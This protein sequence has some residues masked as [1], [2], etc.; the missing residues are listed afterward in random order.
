MSEKP[1]FTPSSY[2][3]NESALSSKYTEDEI[4]H[5][6]AEV[7]R[8]QAKRHKRLHALEI[9]WAIISTIFAII[10]TAILLAKNWVEGAVSY[11]ILGILI[12][13]I[14]VFLVL[15]ALVYKKP[16]SDLS[17]KVYGKTI[18]IFKALASIAFLVLT[19]MTMAAMVKENK[20]L[21]LA[22]WAIF[23]GNLLVAVV[24]LVIKLASL[25]SY[26]TIRH[27]S[28]HYSVQVSRYVDGEEQKKT[29]ADR[30]EEKKFK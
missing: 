12:A 4:M 25:I 20:H 17:F 26:L 8:E 3:T 29:F 14:I 30:H 16:D 5:A 23:I 21:D 19:A 7:E 1:I 6:R 18:K 10:S 27:T 13:Y 24:K 22:Q 9:A 15:C 28:K 11:A 2:H